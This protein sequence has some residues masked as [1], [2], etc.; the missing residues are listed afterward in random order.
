MAAPEQD[1]LAR[2][3]MLARDTEELRPTDAFS[4]AVMATLET[5]SAASILEKAQRETAKIAPADGFVTAVMQS[6]GQGSAVRPSQESDWNARVVR[7]SRFALMGAAA[8]AGFCLWLSIQ[9][10]SR[11]EAT[12]IEDVAELEVDE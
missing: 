11:F 3:E 7:F 6:V 1:P 8:A 5:T 10:E 2:L 9:A 12:I 4:D